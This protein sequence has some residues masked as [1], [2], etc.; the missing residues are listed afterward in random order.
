MSSAPLRTALNWALTFIS[1]DPGYTLAFSAPLL[2]LSSSF[3]KRTQRRWRKSPSVSEPP[4]NW[5]EIFSGSAPKAKRDGSSSDGAT[6][7]PVARR[8]RRV[9]VMVLS[10]VLAGKGSV[11]ARQQRAEARRAGL[12]AQLL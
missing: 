11:L 9:K 10:P 8:L 6:A 7:R 12:E 4:G 5:C 3:A 1:D 2:R